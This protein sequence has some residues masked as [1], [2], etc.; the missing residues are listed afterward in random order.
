VCT[1]GASHAQ[2][3]RNSDD[4]DQRNAGLLPELAQLQAEIVAGG[5]PE[6]RHQPAETDDIEID[7]GLA[8]GGEGAFA[9]GRLPFRRPPAMSVA[10]VMACPLV[11]GGEVRS[12]GTTGRT[13]RRLIGSMS[14]ADHLG[15]L[16][17][18]VALQADR[19]A[20]EKAFGWRP[21][22]GRRR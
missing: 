19:Q 1:I 20:V 14:V 3:E 6:D 2:A 10:V 22:K 8:D 4:A 11:G 17:G 7:G 21:S 12:A 13:G 5:D 9:P 15:S 18:L 16:D